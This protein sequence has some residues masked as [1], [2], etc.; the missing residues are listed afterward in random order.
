MKLNE[1]PLPG[2]EDAT[3]HFC[4]CDMKNGSSELRVP[5]VVRPQ[6]NEEAPAPSPTTFGELMKSLD[7][8]P[9]ISLRPQGTSRHT[10]SH[11]RVGSVKLQSESS[12]PSGELAA[13]PNSST[14][15]NAKPAEQ[16][17]CYPCI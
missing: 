12:I 2:W 17:S 1:L 15:L 6:T 16:V 9:V 11:I 5:A 3:H 10:N 4:E 8:V 7:I 13:E 14:L